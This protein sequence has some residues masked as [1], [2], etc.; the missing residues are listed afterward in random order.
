MLGFANHFSLPDDVVPFALVTIGY[1]AVRP[2]PRTATARAVSTGTGDK[3]ALAL[4]L[5]AH[6]GRGAAPCTDGCCW[7]MQ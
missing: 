2:R 4:T 7:L 6:S 1:P 3:G 5:H